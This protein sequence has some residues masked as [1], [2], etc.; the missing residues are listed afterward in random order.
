MRN[1]TFQYYVLLRFFGDKD[2]NNFCIDSLKNYLVEQGE[3]LK[4][5]SLGHRIRFLKSLFNWAHG[6]GY[7]V[8]SSER[9]FGILFP[10]FGSF[11]LV[12]G[13]KKLNI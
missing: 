6:E 11:I 12:A 5:S 10:T 13:L 1:Y 3:H 9:N 4:P 8:S 2:I 7:L